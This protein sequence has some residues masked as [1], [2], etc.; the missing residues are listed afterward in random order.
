MPLLSWSELLRH[1][2]CDSVWC[3]HR[4]CGPP[5]QVSPFLVSRRKATCLL[6]IIQFEKTMS[7][8]LKWQAIF[9]HLLQIRRGS[10]REFGDRHV[11]LAVTMGDRD[12][13]LLL[14]LRG[15]AAESDGSS[16][17]HAGHRQGRHRARPSGQSSYLF[18]LF[19]SSLMILQTGTNSTPSRHTLTTTLVLSCFCVVPT[20]LW[21]RKGQWRTHMVPPADSLYLRERHP[22]RFPGC[23][24][25]HPLHV[26]TELS[27]LLPF[28]KNQQWEISEQPVPPAIP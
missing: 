27:N 19:I 21:P 14:H 16:S 2:Q 23:G 8:G 3:L 11:G 5:G 7:C 13:L 1:V 17:S 4:G 15:R 6:S 9:S 26:R 10:P 22:H 28:L 20:D 12:R 25:S 24:G 18:T